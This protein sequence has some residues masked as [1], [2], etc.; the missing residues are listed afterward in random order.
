MKKTILAF[1]FVF[2][3]LS[4]FAQSSF[5]YEA[6]AMDHDNSYIIDMNESKLSYRDYFKVA[7][8][9]N[10]QNSFEVYGNNPETQE[11]VKLA[12]VDLSYFS[13]TQSARFNNKKAKKWR[14]YA[15]VPKNDIKYKCHAIAKNNDLIV[16]MYYEDADLS[17][18]PTPKINVKNAQVFSIKKLGAEDFVRFCNLSDKENISFNLYVME[19]GRGKWSTF[20]SATLVGY[21]D[22]DTIN[23]NIDIEDVSYIAVEP[24]QDGNFKYSIT[25]KDDDLYINVMEASLEGDEEDTINDINAVD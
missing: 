9:C 25:V 3:G 22:R 19:N 6:P 15:I 16:G 13:D 4:A 5:D 23:S 14:Y 1:V 12:D 8:Y 21:K 10:T 2:L 18:E 7:L 17:I 20:G 11:W 24:K